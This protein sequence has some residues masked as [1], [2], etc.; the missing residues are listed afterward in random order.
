M[1]FAGV[2]NLLTTLRLPRYHSD[3]ITFI[4]RY[5]KM[6]AVV[7]GYAFFPL[8]NLRG[9]RSYILRPMALFAS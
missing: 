8:K 6:D 7:A 3:I 4:A 9:A 2:D 5:K 1:E